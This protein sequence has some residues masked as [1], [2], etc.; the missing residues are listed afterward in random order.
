MPTG[1]TPNDRRELPYWAVNRNARPI[2]H[3]RLPARFVYPLRK[4]PGL[5][6][7]ALKKKLA[8]TPGGTMG[9]EASVRRTAQ[10]T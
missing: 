1:Q 2:P 7:P 9:G 6:E 5:N 3:D 4:P 10:G 8:Y